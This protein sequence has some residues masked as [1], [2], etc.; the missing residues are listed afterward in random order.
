MLGE[1]SCMFLSCHAKDL[2]C[3]LPCW[4]K[5]QN[6]QPSLD[7]EGKILVDD[8]LSTVLALVKLSTTYAEAPQQE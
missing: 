5:D 2:F 7:D 8:G 4:D 3:F 1:D 6:G